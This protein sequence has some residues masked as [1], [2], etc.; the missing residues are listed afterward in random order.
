MVSLPC[1]L[2]SRG[3]PSTNDLTTNIG[4]ASSRNY[5][6]PPPPPKI[7]PI[8]VRKLPFVP[9]T[10]LDAELAPPE[11]SN[12]PNTFFTGIASGRLLRRGGG[13]NIAAVV[14][15]RN[16]KRYLRFAS[17]DLRSITC[18]S[19]EFINYNQLQQ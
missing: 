13:G 1:A 11:L 9:L 15:V 18:S 10:E 19:C 7:L 14:A 6:A 17:V 2:L 8:P 12:T 5:C 3:P 16:N 4:V